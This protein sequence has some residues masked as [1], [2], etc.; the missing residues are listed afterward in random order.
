[1][2]VRQR[3][4][5]NSSTSSFIVMGCIFETKEEFR[6][7]LLPSKL[8]E[9]KK[10]PDFD[11]E[12]FIHDNAS[13]YYGDDSFAW[14]TR[15][16]SVDYIEPIASFED[17]KEAYENEVKSFEEYFGKDHNLDIE[18]IGIRAE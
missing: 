1:M 4:V 2:K 13:T 5:S 3:F 18:L 16:G 7:K 12:D 17:I 10:D 8:A 14:G 11:L 6:D 9:L 15:L